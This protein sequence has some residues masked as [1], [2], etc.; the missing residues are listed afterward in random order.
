MRPIYE[1][2]LPGHSY[3]YL[4]KK[5]DYFIIEAYDTINH[6]VSGRGKFSFKEDAFNLTQSPISLI[7]YEIVFNVTFE[8]R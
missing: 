3:G 2:D 5:N 1:D 7:T 8:V 4:P 6:I